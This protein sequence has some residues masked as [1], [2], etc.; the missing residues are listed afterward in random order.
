MLCMG[1]NG[2]KAFSLEEAPPCGRGS[3][4]FFNEKFVDAFGFSERSIVL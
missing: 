2:N 4:L 3:S 1:M